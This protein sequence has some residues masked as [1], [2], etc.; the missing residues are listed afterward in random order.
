VSSRIHFD[1]PDP[2]P[3][4][5]NEEVV[6]FNDGTIRVTQKAIFIGPPHNQ[7][8]AISQVIGVSHFKKGEGIFTLLGI[9]VSLS[10]FIISAVLLANQNY[11]FCVIVAA[12][13]LYVLKQSITFDWQVALQ[14]GGLNNQSLTMKNEDS[15]KTLA[16]CITRAMSHLPPPPPSGG[17]PVAYQPYF[18]NP[19]NSR[20]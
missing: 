3:A 20:N 12:F 11:I 8:F 14:F 17:E 1:P 2:V 9:L 5:E 10:A 6:F 4:E 18:P 19:V 16:Y 13:A 15:A 7:A